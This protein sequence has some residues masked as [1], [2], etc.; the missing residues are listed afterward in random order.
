MCDVNIQAT[1]KTTSTIFFMI[2][3]K[4]LIDDVVLTTL[5]DNP[6]RRTKRTN[7]CFCIEDNYK[8]GNNKQQQL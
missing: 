3:I 7:T 2:P 4:K 1:A 6:Q 5:R 8:Y